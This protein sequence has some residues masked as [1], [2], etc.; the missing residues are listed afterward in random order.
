[1]D[2]AVTSAVT[3]AGGTFDALSPLASPPLVTSGQAIGP[4]VL[5]SGN[6]SLDALDPAMFDLVESLYTGNADSI[7]FTSMLQ[8]LQMPTWKGR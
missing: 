8:I 6:Q 1:M 3:V 2:G 5:F 7:G 4:G